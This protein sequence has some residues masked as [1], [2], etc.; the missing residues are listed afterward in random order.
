MCVKRDQRDAVTD[1]M[2]RYMCFTAHNEPLLIQGFR[3]KFAYAFLCCVLQ[4]CVAPFHEQR[5]GFFSGSSHP[6]PDHVTIFLG[7]GSFSTELSGLLT[8]RTPAMVAWPAA[9]LNSKSHG[10]YVKGVPPAP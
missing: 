4:Y 5:R 10:T 3:L 9:S 6:K 8:C 1:T 7:V 2:A